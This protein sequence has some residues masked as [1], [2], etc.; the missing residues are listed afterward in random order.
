MAFYK[1][2]TQP[3]KDM[4]PYIENKIYKSALALPTQITRS[5]RNGEEITPEVNTKLIMSRIDNSAITLQFS[6][7]VQ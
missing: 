4:F 2:E 7:A 3:D 5:V 1:S 6:I